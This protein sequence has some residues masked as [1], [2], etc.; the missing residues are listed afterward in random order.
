MTP[1][2]ITHVGLPHD[3]RYASVEALVTAWSSDSRRILYYV[4][5]GETECVDCDDRGDWEIR[6]ADYGFYVYDLATG[7]SKPV[8]LPGEFEIWLPDGSLLLSPLSDQYADSTQQWLIRFDLE[9]GRAHPLGELRGWFTQ[10]DASA[11]ARW[12]L[13]NVGRRVEGELTSQVFKVNLETGEAEPVTPVS[14]WATFQSPRFSPTARAAAHIHQERLDDSGRP[15][16]TLV[17]DGRTLFE[18]K[19]RPERLGFEWVTDQVLAVGCGNEL[20]ILD[21]GSGAAKARHLLQ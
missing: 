1:L 18:C 9:N 2:R 13:V 17:V 6:E 19:P 21:A 5:H 20:F 7:S 11:D 15:H 3:E 14:D 16:E 12:L 8:L 4:D 10:F